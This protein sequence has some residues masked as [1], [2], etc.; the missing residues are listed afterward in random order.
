[1]GSIHALRGVYF[2]QMKYGM[3]LSSLVYTLFYNLPLVVVLA[4]IASWSPSSVPLDYL[5]VGV[6]LM[7]IWNWVVI[8]T[9]WAIT[10]EFYAGIF[11][12]TLTS[13]TPLM[14]V[15][16][17]RALA[18]TTA[19]I[20]SGIVSFFVI[21]LISKQLIHVSN[22]PL[23]LVSLGIAIFGII[24]VG[25][26]FAPFFL[27]VRGRAGFF[28]VVRPIGVVLAGFLYPVA[29]LSSGVEVLARILPIS[30]A[31]DGIIYSLEFEGVARE[32]I[33]H[34][35]I[36][37]ALSIAFLVATYLLIRKVEDRI[38]LSGNLSYF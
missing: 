34:L 31:M 18:L 22:L 21:L 7:A 9:G 5:A 11:D 36:A 17:G 25:L 33:Y 3:D 26:I 14:L 13:R 8:R 1:M 4:W 38:R 2:Q 23:L 37:L 20:P 24:S 29:F 28:N 32:V 27:L 10:F 6:F 35:G 12:Y 15:V 16:F 30:W 19:G